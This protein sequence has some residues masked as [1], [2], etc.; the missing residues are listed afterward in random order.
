M[1][2]R[3]AARVGVVKLVHPHGLR[4]TFADEL[5]QAVTALY[6]NHLTNGAA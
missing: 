4:H 3:Q 2:K 1:L 6:L 5:R